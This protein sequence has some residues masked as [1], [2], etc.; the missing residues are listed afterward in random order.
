[1]KFEF[2]PLRFEWIALDAIQFPAGLPA[3][4]LRGALGATFRR[5]N[6]AP[7]CGGARAC[8]QRAYCPYARVFEPRAAGSGPSGLADWPRPFCFRARHLDGRSVLPGES[9]DFDLHVFARDP[10]M[11]AFFVL[12]FDQIARHGLGPRRGRAELRV[13]RR[14][15]F[16]QD[17]GPT[18]F[19]GSRPVQPITPVALDLAAA[20]RPAR[21]LRVEF[22]SPTELISGER[23]AARPEFPILF[24]RIRD[25]ISTLRALYG[26]GP[27]EIDFRASAARAA[28]VRMTRSEIRRVEYRRRSSRTGRRHPIGGFVGW[29]DYEG[30]LTDF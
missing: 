25:R 28:A 12:T 1:M 6:C 19:E 3:N 18:L 15:A 23:P 7:E 8:D 14:I 5:L 27:L 21:R 17:P 22:L 16:D 30:E 9:F 4:L 29:A 26:A 2:Y 20:A 13:V 10:A 11:P 24:A